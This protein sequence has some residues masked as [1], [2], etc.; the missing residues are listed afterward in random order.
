MADD[1]QSG[2]AEC[3]RWIT[4]QPRSNS[5]VSEHVDLR[6]LQRQRSDG[7]QCGRP[8]VMLSVIAG[9]DPARPDLH[10]ESGQ[11][12][13]A[14]QAPDDLKDWRVAWSPTLNSLFRV[15]PEVA[16]ITS[17]AARRFAELGCR[18]DGPRGTCTRLE[19]SST[20]CARSAPLLYT[21]PSSRRPTSWTA[22]GCA[23]FSRSTRLSLGDVARAESLHGVLWQRTCAFFETSGCCCCQRRSSSRSPATDRTPPTTITPW[24]IPW[25]RSCPPTRST[26]R[27]PALSVP[28]GMAADGTP[29]GLQIVG[30]WRRELDVLHAGA[31]FER[32]RPGPATI[33]HRWPRACR[34][35]RRLPPVTWLVTQGEGRRASHEPAD[36]PETPDAV[37]ASDTWPVA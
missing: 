36:L 21:R 8:G 5:G 27:V 10:S 16:R 22:P 31:V 20:A 2:G 12:F 14:F 11:A 18:V 19:K 34:Q 13:D 37:V 7:A 29:V 30:G 6:H 32:W 35:R 25:R 15:E 9:P 24:P 17:A 33:R 4:D 26:F 28:C 1:S 23:S 3:N